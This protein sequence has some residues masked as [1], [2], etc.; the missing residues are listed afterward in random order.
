MQSLDERYLKALLERD[1]PSLICQVMGGAI[2]FCFSVTV[3][4][5]A[6]YTALPDVMRYNRID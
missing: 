6:S 4:G 5:V 2:T 3:E 1:L